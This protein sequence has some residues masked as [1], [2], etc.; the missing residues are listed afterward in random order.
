MQA[1][2]HVWIA[3]ADEAATV[4]RLMTAFRDHFGRDWP[5]D[6][7]FLAGVERLLERSQATFLLG[8]P[9][10]DAPPAGVVQLRFR[11]SLWTAV[12][13]CW[14]EDLF[15]LEQ[16]RGAGLGR[17]LVAQAVEVARERG[18]RRIELDVH[19]H[20]AGARRLYESL[21]FARKGEGDEGHNL[22]LVAKLDPAA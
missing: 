1:G 16:A 7:A 13:D 14:L 3:A 21:G 5:S 8:A 22:Y 19:E 17:A 10:P 20:N 18:C 2:P 6:N 12:D 15:V 9:G 11:H 4:A